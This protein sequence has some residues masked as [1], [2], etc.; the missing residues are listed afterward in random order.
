MAHLFVVES[1]LTAAASNSEKLSI[2]T[3][4]RHLLPTACVSSALSTEYIA[5]NKNNRIILP[6]SLQVYATY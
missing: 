3:T 2:Y 6:L 1:Q 5:A 4:T